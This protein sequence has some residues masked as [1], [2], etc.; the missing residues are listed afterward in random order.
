MISK[1]QVHGAYELY[2]KV[3]VFLLLEGKREYIQVELKFNAST[4]KVIIKWW[5]QWKD[6]VS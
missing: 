4:W 6:L 1:G 5:L 2:S 3:P